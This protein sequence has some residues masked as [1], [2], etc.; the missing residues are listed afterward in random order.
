M[1]KLNY[2]FVYIICISLGLSIT[3]CSNDDDG[4]GEEQQEEEPTTLNYF[5]LTLDNEW[6]YDYTDGEDTQILFYTTL[7]Y[8]GN[9]FLVTDFVNPFDGGDM[10]QGFRLSGSTYYGYNGETVIEY[11]S[12]IAAMATIDPVEYVFFKD[13]MEV[14]E[15]YTTEVAAPTVIESIIDIETT[16]DF[17]FVTTILSKE[18]EMIVNGVTYTD[19]IGV[20]LDVN[21][22]LMDV[23]FDETLI[24]Y[25]ANEVGPIKLESSLGDYTI[26]NYSLN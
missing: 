18:E 1:K 5:P 2:L 24:Y 23:E 22:S 10:T 9:T 17:T 14:G 21:T 4:A 20:Q 11:N 8:E 12:G 26:L 19:V 7:D 16:T 15:T 3:S 6:N 25:F 13:D